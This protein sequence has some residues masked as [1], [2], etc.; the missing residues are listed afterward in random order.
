MDNDR[1]CN[2]K[3]KN[4][5]IQKIFILSFC[6]LLLLSVAVNFTPNATVNAAISAEVYLSSESS[7]TEPISRSWYS[8]TAYA[9]SGVQ[10][11]LSRQADITIG[12]P[13]GSNVTAIN[14]NPT[15]QYQTMLGLGTS[16]EE[17]TIYNLSRMSSTKR[18]EVLRKLIDPVNGAGMNIF[19]ITLGT[20]DF[21][22]RAFYTYEDTQGSFSI[23]K[24]I[25]FNIIST[26][27]QAIA[28]GN[29]TG[30]PIKIFASSWSAPGWMKT[31]GS[32]IGGS[33]KSE[34]TN[35]LA[36][37][38]RKAIQEYESRGIPI[39]AMT[40]QNEPLFSAPDY[41][42]MLLTSNNER[43]LTIAMKNEFNSN[44][45][46]TKL[47]SFDHN[48]SDALG[49]V[50]GIYN[51]EEAFAAVDAVAFHDYGG[52]PTAMTDVH[53]AY[54]SKNMLV[55]ERTLFGTNGADRIAQYFR[56][57]AISYDAWVTMLDQ[58]IEPER[59]TRV[60]DPTM[61]IQSPTNRDTYWVLPEFNF[62]AQY[63]KF[64]KTG[65]KR[66]DSNYGTTASVTNVSFLNPDNSIVTVVINQTS[67][68]QSFKILSEGKE[69]LA[70][71]PAKTVGTYKWASNNN[72]T[73]APIGSTIAIK[74]LANNLYV[75][76]E[77]AG[78][79]PL[80]ANRSSVSGWEKFIV[81]DAGGGF[82]ALKALANNKYV[83][84]ENSGVS[85]LI[86]NRDS[87]SGWEQFTW[88]NNSDGSFSLKANANGKYVTAENGGSSPLIAN[89]DSIDGWEK[90]QYSIQ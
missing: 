46:S 33:F 8:N 21:T 59:W 18:D 52:E 54:P 69:I 36:T 1:N 67:S 38:Y 75:C 13:S 84:A 55:S 32:L 74:A 20:S 47:W 11:Q 64:V 42:S 12:N 72:V 61:L 10:Y 43:D 80:I 90:F 17:S 5:L 88:V 27:Q 34:F 62:I 48:F 6:F 28:I 37:Y 49:Y 86:A 25:D 39:Y 82:I 58:N 71:L 53:N 14:V 87:F 2:V 31:S 78:V 57:W 63:A 73:G 24:D 15:I 70:T 44:G 89:R 7:N 66:I 51:N 79:S 29:Q 68:D 30:N 23:Q 9:M 22:S 19:R 45:I 41:P 65:A 77:D 26:V 60:P 3:Q 83:T 56:N 85:S 40:I 35:Q 50:S 4:N 16:L 81:V 76:A